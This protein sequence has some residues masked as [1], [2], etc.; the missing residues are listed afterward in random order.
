MSLYEPPTNLII[1]GLL[2]LVVGF[3]GVL[4]SRLVARG[5]RLARPLDLVR[6]IRVLILALVAGLFAVG[7]LSGRSGFVIL[8]A[9]ILAE[10]L[11]ETGVLLAII[12]L[13]ERGAS[14]ARVSL[15][16]PAPPV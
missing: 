10:E 15:D 14:S 16:E 2:A 4:S 6:G 13:G 12:R 7:L 5:I 11:Y 3:S 9:I 8:G 1:S